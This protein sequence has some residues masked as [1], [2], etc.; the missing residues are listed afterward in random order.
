MG[1][2]SR[3]LGRYGN[4]KSFF[5]LRESAVIALLHNQHTQEIALVNNRRPQ[6]GV[7]GFFA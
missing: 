1:N 7:K 5:V 2:Q 4:E 6:E 3:Q